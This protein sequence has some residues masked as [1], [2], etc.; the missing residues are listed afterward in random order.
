MTTATTRE[1]CPICGA[2]LEPP[3]FE[4]RDDGMTFA[5]VMTDPG[6]RW[7]HIVDEHPAEFE[8]VARLRE[9][10]NHGPAPW[11]YPVYGM[12]RKVDGTF[13]RAGENVR[14]IARRPA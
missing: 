14:D 9:R 4:D 13:L 1:D 10:T 12:P 7:A 2:E 5:V 8:R 11:G 3:V 6:T